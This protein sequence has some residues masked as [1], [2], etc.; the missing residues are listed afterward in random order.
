MGLNELVFQAIT[1]FPFGE[2]FLVPSSKYLN[3]LIH[4][5][6]RILKRKETK[7]KKNQ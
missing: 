3:F 1:D 7:K 6:G 5:D 4:S 2:L